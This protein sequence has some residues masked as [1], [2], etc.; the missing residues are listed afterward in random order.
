MNWTVIAG[1]LGGAFLALVAQY[2]WWRKKRR[3][4]ITIKPEPGTSCS[5]Q[6]DGR[7]EIIAWGRV[8]VERLRAEDHK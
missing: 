5:I 2:L 3:G 4:I 6:I 1:F 8:N 7:A